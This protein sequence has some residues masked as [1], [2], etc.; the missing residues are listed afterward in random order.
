MI[1]T[2]LVRFEQSDGHPLRVT[3]TASAC[4]VGE[5][6]SALLVLLWSEP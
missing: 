5:Q 4:L 2:R 3:Q 1:G 6:A